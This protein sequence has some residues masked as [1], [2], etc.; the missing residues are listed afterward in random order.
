MS[1]Y[2]AGVKLKWLLDNVPEIRA[3]VPSLS[4][5]GRYL[6]PHR[7]SPL[8]KDL[9]GSRR[10]SKDISSPVGRY[11]GAASTSIRSS[12]AE[13]GSSSGCSTTSPRSAPR[14]RCPGIQLRITSFRSSYTGL[15]PQTLPSEEGTNKPV[16]PDSGLESSHFEY[17]SLSNLPIC[18]LLACS[19]TS[20]RS[21]P[22]C[23]CRARKEHIQMIF[24]F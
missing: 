11:L 2:F 9:E 22:K 16:R 10:I 17:R 24:S 4:P 5:T 13:R 12:A 20:P 19:T 6:S 15:Y 18:P 8:S 23:R 7:P 1:T 14:C 3:K 21:A